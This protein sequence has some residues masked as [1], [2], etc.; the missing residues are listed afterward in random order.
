MS[1]YKKPTSGERIADFMSALQ[2]KP[3]ELF[4]EVWFVPCEGGFTWRASEDMTGTDNKKQP[5]LWETYHMLQGKEY[6]VVIC[7]HWKIPFN[8]SIWIADDIVKGRTVR[9]ELILE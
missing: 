7:S 1:E 3:V 5:N 6:K 2:V 8:L 4:I 9:H